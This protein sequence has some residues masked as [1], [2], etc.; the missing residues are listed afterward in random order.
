LAR[1][2]WINAGFGDCCQR[3]AMTIGAYRVVCAICRFAILARTAAAPSHEACFDRH[4]T[5]RGN[6]KMSAG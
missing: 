1:L 2:I 4:A 6:D 5:T 3:C